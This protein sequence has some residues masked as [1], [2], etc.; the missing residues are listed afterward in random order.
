M[1]NWPKYV[2]IRCNKK[3]RL[4][5][6]LLGICNASF[7][8]KSFT[9][10][11]NFQLH[12]PHPYAFGY[13][14]KDKHGEQHR[15]ETGDGA[16][17]VK[18]SYGFTDE[19]G[20]HREVSYVADKAGYRA[21]VKTNEHGT[22]PQDPAAVKMVSSAHPYF[23]GAGGKGVPALAPTGL[24][25]LGTAPLASPG[26]VGIGAKFAAP[27]LGLG[28]AAPG[29]ALYGAGLAAESALVGKSAL[30]FAPGVGISSYAEPLLGGSVKGYDSRFGAF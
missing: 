29:P 30:G 9:C 26:L 7:S 21:E 15:Q 8:L 27:V 13:T 3:R 12:Q 17:G 16:G 1:L 20:V 25:G 2:G 11:L 18:G 24:V 10:P 19:R 6:F 22:A 4:I 5:V 28:F 14:V 23:G